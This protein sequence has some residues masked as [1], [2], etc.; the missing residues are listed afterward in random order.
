[1][2]PETDRKKRKLF[3]N[4]LSFGVRLVIDDHGMIRWR[5]NYDNHFGTSQRSLGT[6]WWWYWHSGKGA[7]YARAELELKALTERLNI[8]V[9]PTPMGKVNHRHLKDFWAAVIIITSQKD[10]MLLVLP[11]L[12]SFWERDPWWLRSDLVI[13]ATVIPANSEISLTSFF[14]AWSQMTLTS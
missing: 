1:M 8:P 14:R 6:S 4:L 2:I 7:A 13:S 10:L 11:D 9:L 3:R 12:N 5:C